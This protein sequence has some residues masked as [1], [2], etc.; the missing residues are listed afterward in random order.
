[1]G[2]RAAGHHRRRFLLTSSLD[3]YSVD[4]FHH[5]SGIRSEADGI[6]GNRDL[7]VP[8]HCCGDARKESP[9][10]GS[11]ATPRLELAARGPTSGFASSSSQAPTGQTPCS[12]SSRWGDNN[13]RNGVATVAATVAGSGGRPTN[14]TG[15]G[16]R[17]RPAPRSAEAI[18]T[19]ESLENRG[20][21]PRRG[22]IDHQHY[23]TDLL[24]AVA[25]AENALVPLKQRFR[26]SDN[27]TDSRP[28]GQR[29]S[30][31]RVIDSASWPAWYQR[32]RGA[33]TARPGGSF[34]PASGVA[35]MLSSP[36]PTTGRLPDERLSGTQV[37]R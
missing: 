5:W 13:F 14:I 36:P 33:E 35:G 31:R 11:T 18:S 8:R 28:D 16:R 21:N 32:G 30:C 26:S 29:C 27:P 4:D 7:S 23:A 34:P 3:Y 1:M 10:N 22:A 15:R 17:H 19:A 25:I 9:W 12:S 2:Q 20:P 37:S 6:G 24:G